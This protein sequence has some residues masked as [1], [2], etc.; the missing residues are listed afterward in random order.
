MTP[1]LRAGLG[2]YL[3][4][5]KVEGETFEG[6]DDETDLG[7][8]IGGGLLIHS[9]SN[10]AIG[11]DLLYHYIATEDEAT[12]LFTLRAVLMFGVGGE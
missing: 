10:M 7:F 4:K 3:L 1:F 12:N 11:G 5:T 9:S 8:N 2:A 6:D